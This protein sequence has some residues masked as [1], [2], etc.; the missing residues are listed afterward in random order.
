MMYLEDPVLGRLDLE[1]DDDYVVASFE[2]GWPSVRE[3][4][5][6][7]ALTDGS[8]DTTTYLGPRAVTVSLRLKDRNCDDTSTTQTLLDRLTP[9]LSPRSRPLL[10]WTVREPSTAPTDVRTLRLRGADAPM[11][12]EGP[13]YLSI[14]CQWISQD[15]YTAALDETCAVAVTTGTEEFGRVYDLDFDR[16]YP[17]SPP[18]GVTLFNTL[19]NAPMDWTGTVTSD[20][21]DPL[22]TINGINIQFT[23]LTLVAGAT[24]NIDTQNRTILRN[25]DPNDSVYGL[26]N[27]T[28]W[29][30]DSI[31]LQPGQNW[32][33]M[34][35]ATLGGAFTVCWFDRW[36]T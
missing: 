7:R 28:D 18:F 12:V 34:I 17:F 13:H 10:V 26:A 1:C 25:N 20:V 14:V 29:D 22:L 16:D 33:R 2:I 19:G 23:G 3:V 32:I 8:I 4:I 35:S 15:P 9:Y 5:D 30:W 11:I 24:V 36:Y 27:F 6:A 21:V 31:R